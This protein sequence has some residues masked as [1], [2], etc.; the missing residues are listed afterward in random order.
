M[1]RIEILT[2][3]GS[4]IFI[5]IIAG[6]GKGFQ[7]ILTAS[8]IFNISGG[9]FLAAMEQLWKDICGNPESV[10]YSPALADFLRGE[11]HGRAKQGPSG[12]FF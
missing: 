12:S 1:I 6:F 11:N 9:H 3:L 10:P 5:Y 7:E 4:R 2:S 8:R